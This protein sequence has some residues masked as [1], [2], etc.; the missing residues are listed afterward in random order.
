MAQARL[1]R[2]R[3]ITKSYASFIPFSLLHLFCILFLVLIVSFGLSISSHQLTF[4]QVDSHQLTST[5]YTLCL[6]TSAHCLILY[7]SSPYASLQCKFIQTF[8]C[9]FWI[10]NGPKC[11]Q[12]FERL[13]HRGINK[14]A[15]LLQDI[16]LSLVIRNSE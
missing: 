16:E 3:P 5:C 8:F 10:Q 9:T 14:K 15:F 2:A 6:L 4:A 11:S 1:F 12:G 7:F 13:H